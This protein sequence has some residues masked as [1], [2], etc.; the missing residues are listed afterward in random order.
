[1]TNAGLDRAECTPAI[2][3]MENEPASLAARKMQ[4]L[5][6]KL[7][8]M[9][10]KQQ[11]LWEMAPEYPRVEKRPRITRSEF[12]IRHVLGSRPL[13]LTGIHAPGRR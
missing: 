11:K 8:S 3:R 4:Q 6:R 9:L 10:A 7:E 12:I 13:V 1:M 2:R 5:Q